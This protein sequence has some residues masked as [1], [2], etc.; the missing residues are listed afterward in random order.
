MNEKTRKIIYW[1][2]TTMVAFVFIG[3]AIG[4]FTANEEALKMVAGM[5]IDAMSY[6]MIGIVELLAI[7]L[8]IYPRTGVIGTLLLAA[9]MGGAIATHLEHAQ[10]IVIPCAIQAFVWCVAVF[11]FPELLTRLKNKA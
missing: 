7:V 10:S 2:L 6:K 3:S 11:R 8:F 5:G 9:Y 1:G 4:K